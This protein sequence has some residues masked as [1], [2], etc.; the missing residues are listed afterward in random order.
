MI[1]RGTVF[2]MDDH[3]LARGSE[4]LKLASITAMI[5]Q[6]ISMDVF[7]KSVTLWHDARYRF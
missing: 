4:Q 6:E 7:A 2:A 3:V 1:S 5:A